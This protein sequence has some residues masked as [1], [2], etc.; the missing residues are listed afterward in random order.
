MKRCLSHI[1]N[2][3]KIKENNYWSP[4]LYMK[5][6]PLETNRFFYTITKTFCDVISEQTEDKNKVGILLSGGYDSRVILSCLSKLN[7]N[8]YAFTWK[9]PD[10]EETKIAYKLAKLAGFHHKY[11]PY[12]PN[13]SKL[14]EIIYEM[15]DITE[16]ALPIFEVGRY[17]VTREISD[18][19]DI[20]FSGTGEIIRPVQVPGDY[21]SLSAMFFINADNMN[22]KSTRNF[23]NTYPFRY[24][25]ST[26]NFH[27]EDF[28]LSKTEKL[29]I[30][31]INVAYRKLYS[32]LI[33]GESFNVPISMP[34]LDSRLIELFLKCPFSIARLKSWKKNIFTTLRG[35]EIYY[36][37]IKNTCPKLLEI[38]LDRGYPP[39]WDI[40]LKGFIMNSTLG[41][42][43]FLISRKRRN[44]PNITPW[45]KFVYEILS[46]TKTLQR[47]FYN[48]QKIITALKNGPKWTPQTGYELEKV[49][50]FELWYRHFFEKIV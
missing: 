8:G 39:T 49:A 48:K 2:N 41:I 29:T 46:E 5:K 7:I 15:E 20:L 12:Y 42:H 11:I 27:Y 45:K 4:S 23:F 43:N 47:S 40:G 36:H 35:R 25:N 44:E 33:L 6:P 17:N 22:N 19:V 37:I 28:F 26:I 13:E 3:G 38:P 21:I 14:N 32:S 1:W 24:L 34:F 50:R 31:L 10:I 9:N 16:F 30:Y 18:E